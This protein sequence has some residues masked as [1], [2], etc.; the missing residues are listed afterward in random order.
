MT[1]STPILDAA[2]EY[3]GYGWRVV[4]VQPRGKLPIAGKG[5]QD[6]ATTDAETINAW[7]EKT[8]DANVGVRLGELSG[9]I[10]FEG[11][12]PEA[13]ETFRK[14]FGDEPPVAPT[15][16]SSRGK[17]RIFAYRDDLPGRGKN[18]FKVGDLEIRTGYGGNAAQSVFPPSEH[19]SGVRY[20]W[21][22]SPAECPPAQI[23]DAVQAWLWNFFDEPTAAL[24]T[25][26]RS[27]KD[28][29]KIS[30]GVSEGNRNEACASY[31]GLLIAVLSDP[32]NNSLVQTQFNSLLIWN[33]QN[34]PP[35][36][37]DEVK[38]TFES[39]LTRHRQQFTSTCANEHF[40]REKPLQAP[41]D[42]K[43]EIIESRPRKYR[44]YSPL[45]AAKTENGFI[46]LCV[47]E[48]MSG[49][50]IR[51][52]A[53]EQS[54]VWISRKSFDPRWEG[55]KGVDSLAEQLVA[56]A[57]HVAAEPEEKRDVMV[58]E[59]VLHYLERANIAGD[60]AQWPGPGGRPTRLHD[61]SVWFQV[62]PLLNDI[63]NSPSKY[64]LQEIVDVLKRAGAANKTM[65]ADGGPSRRY[66]VLDKIGMRTVIGIAGSLGDAAAAPIEAEK[67]DETPF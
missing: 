24:E 19:A 14:M 39:I 11:D 36:P 62:S 8:P 59:A 58:A 30:Q 33:R 53:L 22:V 52:A 37:D 12:G 43:L 13:E 42:W 10:D 67:S 61:G 6:K 41:P 28:W 46:E 16:Q 64:K 35:L 26:N 17:H 38:R 1:E 56:T 20:E 44:L 3:A 31:S 7:W 49:H 29:K 2:L 48:M 40:E 15:Y 32:F 9:I 18:H 21:L 66:K 63:G 55:A 34:N 57:E 47:D 45:W 60:D 25:N 27:K 54:D 5:W 65:R 4:P 50:A 23:S 51:K